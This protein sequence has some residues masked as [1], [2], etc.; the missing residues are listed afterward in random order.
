[1]KELIGRVET[2]PEEL[3]AEVIA[4]IEFIEEEH[5]TPYELSEDDR[6]AIVGGLRAAADGHFATTEQV[7]AVFA[8]YRRR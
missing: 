1:M 4:S 3:Q 8:K 5:R 2:W 6:N 7:E